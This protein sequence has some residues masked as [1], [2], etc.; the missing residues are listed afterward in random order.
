[1]SFAAAVVALAAIGQTPPATSTPPPADALQVEGDWLGY[2]AAGQ[3]ATMRG[4]AVLRRGPLQVRA[5]ELVYD[6]IHQHVL[7]RGHVLLVQGLFA[8]IAEEL[9][10]DV[11]DPQRL[12]AGGKR[13]TGWQKQAVSADRLLAA[14]TQ[15]ELRG[16]GRSMLTMTGSHLKRV[17]PDE[18]R[19]DDV[20]FTPCDCTPGAGEPS[21]HIEARH[22]D[23]QAGERA[24]LYWPVIYVGPVPVLP[25]P[26]LYLP[27]TDR[28][29]GLLVPRPVFTAQNGFALD[30]P[31]FVTLGRSYDLTLTPGYYFGRGLYTAASPEPL[32][33]CSGD[34]CASTFYGIRGP[35]LQTE[36]NYA[37]NDK[38]LGRITFGLV[39]DL[40]ERRSPF[41][42]CLDGVCT[43]LGGQRGIRGEASVRHVQD[44]GGGYFDR[45]DASF[46]SDGYYWRDLTADILAATAQYLRST[47]VLYHRD[48]NSYVGVDATLRQDIRWG[49]NLLGTDVDT[50][51]RH[52]PSTLDRLPGFLF[53]LP[54]RPLAGPIWGGVQAQYTRIAP[55]NGLTGDEGP[56]GYYDPNADGTASLTGVGDRVFQPGEREARERIDLNPHFMASLGAGKMVRLVPYLAY[57]ED[58][59]LGEVTGAFSHRGY[60]LAGAE[61]ETELS[62]VFDLGGGNA[63]RHTLTPN[64]ELRAVPY[65]FGNVPRCGQPATPCAYD[66][67]DAAIPGA[68]L[69]P[70]LPSTADRS[71]LQAIADV[72]QTLAARQS[73]KVR[74]ILLLDVGQGFDLL[75]Q[76]AA[77]TFGR[78]VATQGAFS[79]TAV[80]RYDQQAARLAQFSSEV[81][82]DD[83]RGNGAYARFDRLLQGGGDR[84]RAGLD[85]LLGTPYVCSPQDYVQV[86]AA[87]PIPGGPQP[88]CPSFAEQLS[89]GFR[90]KLPFGLAGRYDAIVQ[91]LGT[92]PP[93]TV[94]S[95]LD[96]L[97]YKFAQQV[98]ALSYGPACD[99]WRVE[100]HA[101]FF[102]STPVPNLGVSLTI[103]R[104]GTF[105]N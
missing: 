8:A 85:S 74:Q 39:D 55:L 95:G 61:A 45:I 62:R 93:S 24:I 34:H 19:V 66:E 32:T 54:D 1:V 84:F 60:G 87:N 80:L 73:G 76:K 88:Q 91:P 40:R 78:L 47:A 49:F 42:P 41:D 33:N 10:A 21:W 28:R 71:M 37:P 103:S 102:P 79:T 6:Q 72:R 51:G 18:Y 59:Y 30:V 44:L 81:A 25:L 29:S 43:D 2:D 53:A 94:A 14:Q 97:S 22:S 20:A 98:A 69:N 77:D 105:G 86:A 70:L 23:I 27:M 90:F 100:A 57:R 26:V 17:A 35:R 64:F 75:H 92:P 63:L 58:L 82:V 50:L 12:E 4:R 52:G 48:A 5:D 7:A 46:I 56:S 16:L 36:L 89:A 65:A 99:C 11:Q 101:V 104:F 68:T 31:V 3:V 15:E 96:K 38:T 83:A 9:D 67:I 13:M